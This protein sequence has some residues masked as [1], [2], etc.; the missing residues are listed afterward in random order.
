[1]GELRSQARRVALG[2]VGR[3]RDDQVEALPDHGVEQVALQQP[4]AIREAEA[5]GASEGRSEIAVKVNK[6]TLKRYEQTQ[7]RRG[8]ALAP[9]IGGVCQGCHMNLPPQL[10]NILARF[11]SIETCPSC[12]RLLYR[13]ELLEGDSGEASAE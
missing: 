4:H 5:L 7:K 3:I 2:H 10:S 6:R 8:I 9:V 11:E 12:N 13:I 1:V